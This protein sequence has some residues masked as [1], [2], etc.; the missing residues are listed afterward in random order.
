MPN[1]PK[2]NVLYITNRVIKFGNVTY[3]IQA[4]S[5]VYTEEYKTPRKVKF[6]TTFWGFVVLA[7]CAAMTTSPDVRTVG[8]CGCLASALFLLVAIYRLLQ[9]RRYWV[10]VFAVHGAFTQVVGSRSRSDIEGAEQA[11][12][13]AFHA[14]G[15]ANYSNTYVLNQGQMVNIDKMNGNVNG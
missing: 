4:I 7:I 6:K 5:R 13:A 9:P 12:S 10:L 8:S 1:R 2:S 14:Q 3:P 15:D 11:I